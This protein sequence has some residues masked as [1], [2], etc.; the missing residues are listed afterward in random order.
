PTRACGPALRRRRAPPRSLPGTP[1]TPAA[2]AARRPSS[3]ARHPPP[4]R[5]CP[6]GTGPRIART[7]PPAPGASCAPRAPGTAPGRPRPRTLRHDVR[8]PDPLPSEDAFAHVIQHPVHRYPLLPEG[9]PVP[10]RDRVVLQ[11][12]AVH[13]DGERRAG[14]VLP[15]IAL[16]DRAA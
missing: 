11:R 14:L 7:P 15:A 9:V 10:D 3:P 13:G 5:S 12:L 8:V 16:P 1:A 6:S 4:P 2:D